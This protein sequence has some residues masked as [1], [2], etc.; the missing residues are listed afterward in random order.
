MAGR[1]TS[2]DRFYFTKEQLERTPSRKHGI[3]S[4]KELNYRQQTSNFIQDMGQRLQLNQLCINSAI[5]C[6]HRFYMFH[7]FATFH[8]NVTAVAALFLAAKTEEQPRKIEHVIRVSHALLHKDYQ[9]D[10]RSEQYAEKVW[11]ISTYETEIL[12][13]LGFN[14]NIEH[15]HT[16]VVKVCQ[17][18]KASKDLAQTSYIMATTSLHM[19]TMCL[20]FKPTI[21]A[22]VCIHLACKWSSYRIEPCSQGRPWYYYVDKTVTEELLE[23][24]TEEFV[25]ILETSPHRF[26][27]KFGKDT[28]NPSVPRPALENIYQAGPSFSQFASNGSSSRGTKAEKN[29]NSQEEPSTSGSNGV[30]STNSQ[31]PRVVTENNCPSGPSSSSN[32][33]NGHSLNITSSQEVKLE[34]VETPYQA[35]HSNNSVNHSSTNVASQGPRAPIANAHQSASTPTNT[36]HNLVNNTTNHPKIAFENKKK[37]PSLPMTSNVQESSSYRSNNECKP[38]VTDVRIKKEKSSVSPEAKVKQEKLP[39]SPSK[40]KQKILPPA[41]KIKQEKKLSPK[42]S[43]VPSPVPTPREKHKSK[44]SSREKSSS[45]HSEPSTGIKVKICKDSVSLS[46]VESNQ[47]TPP[48]KMESIKKP[49]KIKLPKP[50]AIAENSRLEKAGTPPLKLVLTK[51]KSGSGSYSTSNKNE[52][53]ESRKRSHTSDS[54]YKNSYEHPSKHAKTEHSHKNHLSDRPNKISRHSS[55]HND[56]D[57]THNNNT[58]SARLQP[59]HIVNENSTFQNIQPMTNYN[60]SFQMTPPPPPPKL[61]GHD[62]YMGK[63][64]SILTAQPPLPPPQSPPPP[65]PPFE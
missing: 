44:H 27:R 31:K 4:I 11:E 43:V 16:Y 37:E 12:Q 30:N 25:A 22:C 60:Y 32:S 2:L 34:R 10:V 36:N 29:K 47:R 61:R 38:L 46:G 53:R 20:Q 59:H 56:F 28:M 15:P 21:V 18:V 39:L 19:T 52:M 42:A 26:K 33:N 54:S 65:P 51:D 7:S 13:T 62:M 40:K 8:R 64:N 9:L 57:N 41:V 35:V 17:L 24:L 23:R 1:S 45:S 48:L 58:S 63:T 14:L 3:D 55:H 6:V 49:I 50:Y 5:V